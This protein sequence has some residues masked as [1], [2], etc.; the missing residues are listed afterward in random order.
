M[1]SSDQDAEI[2]AFPPLFRHSDVTVHLITE[3]I[4]VIGDPGF[5]NE[6]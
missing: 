2:R 1:V 6:G 5:Q 4:T 3:Q